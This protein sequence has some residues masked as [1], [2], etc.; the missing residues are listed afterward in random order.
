MRP[1]SPDVGLQMGEKEQLVLDQMRHAATQGTELVKR[2][3]AFARQQE[4]SPAS[5]DPASLLQKAGLT[6]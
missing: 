3:M 6:A 4:L 2:M 1:Q 5:V